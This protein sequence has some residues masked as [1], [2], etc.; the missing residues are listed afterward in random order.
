MLAQYLPCSAE[1]HECKPK[2]QFDTGKG[3]TVRSISMAKR[4]VPTG[5]PVSF[6]VQTS[7]PTS[8]APPSRPNEDRMTFVGDFVVGTVDCVHEAVGGTAIDTVLLAKSSDG[9]L[10]FH[11]N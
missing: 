1:N 9:M 8:G 3:V 4:T 2:T 10:T 5:A 6:T 11:H 7:L